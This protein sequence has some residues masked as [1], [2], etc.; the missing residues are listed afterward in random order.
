[1]NKGLKKIK[2]KLLKD[3]LVFTLIGASVFLAAVISFGKVFTQKSNYLYVRVKIDQGLWWIRSQKPSSWYI[4]SVKVGEKEYSLLG[5]PVAEILSIRY[6]PFLGENEQKITYD[7][8]LDLKLA[9]EKNYSGSYLFKRGP[10]NVGS[11]VDIEFPSIRITG[12]V[13]KISEK[14]FKE[15]YVEKTV[16]LTKKFA[17]PWEFEAIKI[18]DTY[19]DGTDKVVKII[20]KKALTTRNIDADLFGNILPSSLEKRKYIRIKAKLK[21]LKRDG[22]LIFGEEQ[23]IK[24]GGPLYFATEENFFTG[25]VITDIK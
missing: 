5:K 9:V 6:Y 18:G 4:D 7:I 12:S 1:M 25:F 2:K 13:I 14:P 24:K 11:P 15:T 21:L 10:L 3:Y 23:V 20:D 22:K 19:F 17:F 8:F 16:T